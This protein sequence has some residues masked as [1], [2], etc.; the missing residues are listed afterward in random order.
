MVGIAAGLATPLLGAPNRYALS[1]QP[2]GPGVWAFR[3]ADAPILAENG[4]AIAN[5]GLIDTP[6]GAVLVDAGPSLRYGTALKTAAKRLTG[7]PVVRVYTT[8]VHPDH[9]YGTGAFA[10]GII[11]APQPVIDD[12]QRA[13][14]GFSDGMYRLLGD[15]MR[16]TEPTVPSVALNA[17]HEDFGGRRLRLLTL[18]GHSVA[19]LA[20][21]DEKSGVLFAGDLVFNQ[22]APSTPNANLAGWRSALD[23]LKGLGH[24][25]VLPGHG[26]FDPTPVA[27]IDFT[28]DW[29]DWLEHALT[30]AANAGLDMVEAGNIAL[31]PRFADV[32]AARYEL[33]RSVV[34]F[35]PAIENRVL[36]R[37]DAKR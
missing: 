34:H 37:I 15:W 31:P 3:G 28:R 2:I 8:H 6:A 12:I 32:A 18:A 21:L 10:A 11:A 5:I 13:G 9:F 33:Q 16:G 25:A 36:P 7:K 26:P 14:P 20:V 24:K 29:I 30:D 27:A 4:G 22:R 17:D 35:Y 1:P 23:T 19:D